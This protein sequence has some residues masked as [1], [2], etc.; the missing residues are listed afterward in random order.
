MF[1]L[2]RAGD[3]LCATLLCAGG[4]RLKQTE[5]KGVVFLG[6]GMHSGP[7]PGIQCLNFIRSLYLLDIVLNHIST[8][9]AKL[10]CLDFGG[11]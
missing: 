10:L 4:F 5:A 6:A 1:I 11:E 7:F 8:E 2:P 3:H 9:R